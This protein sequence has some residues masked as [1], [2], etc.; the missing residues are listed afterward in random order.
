MAITIQMDTTIDV[1]SKYNELV[2]EALGDES[3]YS[4]MKE[5]LYE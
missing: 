3:L 5:N 2:Q 4:R 1:V